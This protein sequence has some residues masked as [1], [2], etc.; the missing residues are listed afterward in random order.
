[1]R[2]LFYHEGHAWTGSSRAF[3]TLARGLS[4]R[5]H[6]VTFACPPE[7]PVE[8]RLEFGAYEVLA[9]EADAPAPLAAQRLRHALQERFI[10]VVCVH[11]NREQMVAASAARLAE[12]A[13]VLRRVPIGEPLALTPRARFAMRLTATGFVYGS[14]E[15]LH[16]APAMPL[17]RLAPTVV[18]LGVSAASYDAVRPVTRAS[19]GVPGTGRLLVCLYAPAGRA[20]AANILRVLALLAPRHPELRLALVGPGSDD[21]DLR[22][23]A[24]ALRITKQVSFLGER[25]DQQAVL[26]A[27]DLG[28]VVATGDDGAYGV[29]DFLGA[30]VPVI[31]ERGSIAQLYLPDGIAGL[32]LPPGDAHDAA[33][34]VARLLAHEEERAAMGGA[35]HGRVARDYTDA[36]MVDAF[37]RIAVT[38]SDRARW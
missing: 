29:L 2:I 17:A 9:L 22:M 19:L 21:E 16:R 14:E 12:R 18:P 8:Q 25:D 6:S 13:A 34:G 26:A 28:W 10:Q 3:A 31:A 24:A 15:D 32:L 1:M 4:E 5:G 20:R 30:R 11:G 23:H 37:E 7:T 27:A 33:A 38:A 36:A 35:G